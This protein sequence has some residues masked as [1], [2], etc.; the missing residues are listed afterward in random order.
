MLDFRD[1]AKK[2]ERGEIGVWCD[3]IDGTEREG[4]LITEV[5]LGRAGKP[6]QAFVQAKLSGVKKMKRGSDIEDALLDPRMEPVYREAYARFVLLDWRNVTGPNG[7]QV[8][9]DIELGMQA[10]EDPEFFAW[11][12]AKSGDVDTWREEDIAADSGN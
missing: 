1:I 12:R 8:D 11:V 6:F 3:Y 9:Y 4:D 2:K 10:L 7:E 5:K